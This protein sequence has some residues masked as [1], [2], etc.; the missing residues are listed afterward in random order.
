L[1]ERFLEAD[2]SFCENSPTDG[3]RAVEQKSGLF[4]SFLIGFW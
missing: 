4:G 1:K 2:P 3:K